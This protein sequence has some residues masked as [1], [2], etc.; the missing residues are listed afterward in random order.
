MKQFKAE[1][2]K[3]L[4]LMIN[5]IY[6]NKEVFLRELLSNASDAIDK[7]Y[8][9]SMQENL[10][11]QLADFSIHVERNE[12]DRSLSI[13]DNG[14]GMSK[15]EL[16]QY[17]GVIAKSDSQNFKELL[18][19]KDDINII[20]RFGVG[21]YSC[22]MVAKEVKVISKKYDASEAWVWSSSGIEGYTIK[23]AKRDSVGTTIIL[24]LKDDTEEEHYHQYFEEYELKN[25]IKKY[26]NYIRY[27][28]ILNVE[29]HELDADG[30]ETDK[31]Y[32]APEIINSMAPIWTKKKKDLSVEEINQYFKDEFN[33]YE[34][35]ISSVFLDLEGN[36]PYKAVLFIPRKA[37]YDYYYKSFEKG[38]KLYSNNVLIMEKCPNLLSDYLSFVRGVVSCD[39]DLNISRET[40]QHSKELDKIEKSINKKVRDELLNILKEQRSDY[41][42]FFES[43]GLRIKYSI[44][45]SY[46]ALSEELKDLLIF[47]SLKEDKYLTLEEYT[48]QLKA[49]D[50]YIYFVKEKNISA[51]KSI[52]QAGYL[53]AK[54]EDILLF[55]DDVDEFISKVMSKY[56]NWEFKSITSG[57]LE[58][59]V[60]ELTA[61]EE[62]LLKSIKEVLDDKV[63]AVKF[64]S[65]LGEY[66]VTFTSSGP[67]SV[68]MERVLRENPSEEKVESKKTLEINRHHKLH[69]KLLNIK[70]KTVELKDISLVIYN[71]ARLN[72]GLSVDNLAELIKQIIE[73]LA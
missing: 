14:I 1:S 17:L 4:D 15:E 61:E 16:D 63:E 59:K 34:D 12:N 5:S 48:N 25:L 29:H 2:K 35:P 55:S 31:T 10:G 33:E 32:Q 52:P 50:K 64:S 67:I 6:T 68:E 47:K 13:S 53:L 27:P 28:I 38:L 20:G 56:K 71:L 72:A 43:F 58:E 51:A 22:F 19:K 11:L 40:I 44:W 23:E 37:P 26:S 30:K 73:L 57:S 49:E 69:D 9:K 8:F 7:L 42:Q 70:D 39:L 54:E 46:G 45:E 18:N 36:V 21:F 60:E 62:E 24:T 66:P 41:E 3:I 65:T